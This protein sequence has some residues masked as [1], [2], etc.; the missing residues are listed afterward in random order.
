M[1]TKRTA[2]VAADYI[3]GVPDQPASIEKKALMRMAF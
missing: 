1:V 2:F 3:P